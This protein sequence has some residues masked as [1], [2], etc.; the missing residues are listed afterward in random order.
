MHLEPSFTETLKSIESAVTSTLPACPEPK[1]ALLLVLIE[2]YESDVATEMESSSSPLNVLKFLVEE[3]HLKQS[4]LVP[5]FGSSGTTSEVFSGKRSISKK[6]ALK[7]GE[8]FGLDY[9]LFL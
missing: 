4:D 3:N 6:A 7:L 1:L 8:R 2:F 5:I 9:T